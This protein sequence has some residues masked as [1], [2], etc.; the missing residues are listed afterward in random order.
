MLELVL[1]LQEGDVNGVME[2]G[3]DYEYGDDVFSSSHNSVHVSDYS[4]S[5]GL[6][7]TRDGDRSYG[8][9]DFVLIPDDVFSEIKDPNG[10]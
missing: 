1:Q 10:R 9:N 3:G 5:T 7:T 8:S 4:K 6:S 2:S